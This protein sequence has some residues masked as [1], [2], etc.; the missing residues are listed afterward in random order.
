MVE[1]NVRNSSVIL[2]MCLNLR[3]DLIGGKELF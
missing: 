1:Y 2:R 3:M